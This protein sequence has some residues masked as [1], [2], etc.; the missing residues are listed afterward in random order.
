M[1]RPRSPVRITDL[2]KRYGWAVQHVGS[3]ACSVPGCCGPPDAQ[4]FAYTIGLHGRGHPE[5]LIFGLGF[6]VGAKVLNDVARRVV[7]GRPLAPD[8]VLESPDW[9]FR[10]ATE[11]LPNPADILFAAN[12]HYRLRGG[13]SVDAFQLSYDDALGRFPWQPGCW[14]AEVQPRP[15]TFKA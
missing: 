5:L 10:L 14:N 11:R 2:I 7:A 8:R 6:E 3:G 13:R 9:G 12:R 1:P 4:P 15:G